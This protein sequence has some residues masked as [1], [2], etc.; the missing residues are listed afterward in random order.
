MNCENLI[1]DLNQ[2]RNSINISFSRFNVLR[3]RTLQLV[4][5]T[6]ISEGEEITIQYMTPMLGNT[7][8]KQKIR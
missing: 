1:N 2:F 4:A 6:L 5:Q 3:D 7:Q 8:R